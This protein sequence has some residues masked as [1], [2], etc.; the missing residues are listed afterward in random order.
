MSSIP[1]M[2]TQSAFSSALELETFS[3]QMREIQ[4]QQMQFQLVEAE[5]TMID[6]Q[7]QTVIDNNKDRANAAI[8]GA[9]VQ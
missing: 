7:I 4:K 3:R 6:K 5:R 2:T 8:Q 9:R 1:P